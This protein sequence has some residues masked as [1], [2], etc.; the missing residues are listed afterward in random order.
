MENSLLQQGIQA[1]KTGDHALA[2]KLLVQVVQRDPN[3][4]MAWIWLAQAMESPSQ[5]LDCLRQVL[6][7]N[8]QNEPVRRAVQALSQAPASQPEPE[9]EPE[10]EPEPAFEFEPG[11]VFEPEPE[12]EV[13]PEPA[14]SWAVEPIWNPDADESASFE[15]EPVWA[16]P[17][18][19]EPEPEPEKLWEW[20]AVAPSWEEEAGQEEETKLPWEQEQPETKL[21]W[22][23]E[24][25]ETQFPW[26]QGQT[27]ASPS[28]W[29][30]EPAEPLSP[31]GQEPAQDEPAPWDAGALWADEQPAQAETAQPEASAGEESWNLDAI[32]GEDAG[33]DAAPAWEAAAPADE[34][35]PAW[36]LDDIFTSPPEATPVEPFTPKPVSPAAVSVPAALAPELPAPAGPPSLDDL[37]GAEPEEISPKA[38]ISAPTETSSRPAGRVSLLDRNR[39]DRIRAA[40]PAPPPEEGGAVPP[41]GPGDG[42]EDGAP[43]AAPTGS[44]YGEFDAD[45]APYAGAPATGAASARKKGRFRLLE[46]QALFGR[47]VVVEIPVIALLLWLLLSRGGGGALPSKTLA[48]ACRRLDRAAFAVQTATDVTSRTLEGNLLFSAGTEYLIHNTLVIPAGRQVLI[49]PGAG[50][51][52]SPGTALE[53]QGKLFVCGVEAEPVMFTAAD[54]EPGGW[55]GVRLRHVDRESVMLNYLEIHFA[56]ERALYLEESAPTLANITIANAALFPISLEGKAFPD[57]SSGIVFRDTPFQAVEIR[58]GT[59]PSGEVVW[60]NYGLV[61]VV[62]GLLK[63]GPDTTLEIAPDVVVKVWPGPNSR[64]SG[65]WVQGLLK[66]SGVKFTSVYDSGEDVGGA[67]YLES[68]DPKPGDWDGITFFKS[69]EK[70]L[71]EN[72]L[73]RYAGN[74]QGAVMLRESSPQLQGLTVANSAWYPLSADADSFPTLSNLTMTEN[75][76]ANSLEIRDGSVVRSPKELSWVMLGSAETQ[77]V[78]VV[79]GTLTIEPGAKLKIGPGI[80]V[81]FAEAGKLVVN[82]AVEAVGGGTAANRIIFTS[83][84]DDDFGGDTDGSLS[85]KGTRRWGGVFFEEGNAGPEMQRVLMRYASVH[86]NAGA[87]RLVG[88]EIRDSSQ[89][90]I[91]MQPDVQPVLLTN[92]LSGNAIDGAVVLPGEITSNMKWDTLGDDATQIARVLIG[93]GVVSETATLT[94]GPGVVV[95][96][97]ISGCLSISGTLLTEGMISRPVVFTSLRD[98]AHAGDSNHQLAGA[99]P[100]DWIGLKLASTGKMTVTTTS[101]FY[102]N[103]GVAM[104]DGAV[105]VVTEGRLQIAKGTHAF[106][107]NKAAKIPGEFLIEDNQV[108]DKGCPTR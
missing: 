80:V 19:E 32:W 18:A 90:G 96:S 107:C 2:R 28:P 25:A 108:N 105:P 91:I 104:Y 8:P 49:E 12:P 5:R 20:D 44:P 58:Q 94:L 59:L 40:R 78:R 92:S 93:N 33:A 26:D 66:A 36:G 47:A 48:V 50:L 77:I 55:E 30:Q 74:Q 100:G 73:V 69:S 24:P 37:F 95:K 21:P 10:L 52:F 64:V 83:L 71:L 86:I 70:S 14:T 72:T 1:T 62:T 34:A 60:P 15:E 102:A 99:L 65:L 6:R 53:V 23:Q 67:T 63:V 27:E 38:L 45:A 13:E 75:S 43:Y 3:N 31:W 9:P 85:L 61:Y 56:G 84:Y 106:W 82:G 79:Q 51:I 89:A 87:P 41:F 88:C 101:I 54:K 29:E 98:D 22:E 103:V 57:L 35:A 81:K 16:T 7:I 76:P 39:M 68:R 11:L 4:E 46:W 17:K 97:D 42:G